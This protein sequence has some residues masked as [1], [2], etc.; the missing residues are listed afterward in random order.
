MPCRSDYDEDYTPKVINELDKVTRLLCNVMSILE[1]KKLDKQ[2]FSENGGSK[3]REELKE[4]W[5]DHKKKD[6]IREKE[7]AERIKKEKIKDKALSK[8]TKE[9]RKALNL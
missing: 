4:W 7:E 9:E 1:N 6:K 8:L 5:E 2:I 3:Y